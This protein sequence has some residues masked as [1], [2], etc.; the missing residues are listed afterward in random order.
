[1]LRGSSGDDPHTPKAMRQRLS[2]IKESP[3]EEDLDGIFEEKENQL[4]ES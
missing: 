4:R 2:T 3:P 1:M